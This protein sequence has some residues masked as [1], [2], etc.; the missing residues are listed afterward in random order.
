VYINVHVCMW[1]CAYINVETACLTKVKNG[2]S[3]RNKFD[4]FCT[5][6]EMYN[7][8]NMYAGEIGGAIFVLYVY[9]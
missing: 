3:L 6:L 8:D 9:R 2:E 5:L 7:H 4:Y 1:H